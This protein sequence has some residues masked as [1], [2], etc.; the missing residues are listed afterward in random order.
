[1]ATFVAGVVVEKVTCDLVPSFP[2][3]MSSDP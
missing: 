3:S 2:A 1:M